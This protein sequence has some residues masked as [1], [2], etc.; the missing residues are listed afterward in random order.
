MW[1]E[2]LCHELALQVSGNTLSRDKSGFHFSTVPLVRGPSLRRLKLF[3]H[4]VVLQQGSSAN[5]LLTRDSSETHVSASFVSWQATALIKGHDFC[6]VLYNM[7]DNPSPGIQAP[8]LFS[9][10]YLGGFGGGVLICCLP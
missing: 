6:A 1:G 8:N 9:P 10:R 5:T 2:M 7:H 3:C 4:D